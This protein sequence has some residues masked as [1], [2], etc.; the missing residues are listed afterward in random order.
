M[1]QSNIIFLFNLIIIHQIFFKD[2]YQNDRIREMKRNQCNEIR[3]TLLKYRVVDNRSSANLN[4]DL[5]PNAA[6][7][8]FFGPSG[9]GKSSLI[10][11]YLIIKMLNDL[12]FTELFIMHYI[13]P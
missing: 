6:N 12:L 3:K 13:V 11:F 7:I 5:L 1:Q 10:R 2:Y 4:Y 9:S 8:I